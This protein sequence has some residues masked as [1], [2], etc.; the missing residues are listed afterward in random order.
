MAPDRG[1]GCLTERLCVGGT[2]GV[3]G[4]PAPLSAPPDCAGDCLEAPSI[5]DPDPG[6]E[7]DDGGDDPHYY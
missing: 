2:G 4:F 6:I 5:D 3:T 1:P 7:R